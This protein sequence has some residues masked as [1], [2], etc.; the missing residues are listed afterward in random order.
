MKITSETDQSGVVSHEV[1]RDGAD[2]RVK[3]SFA[4]GYAGGAYSITPEHAMELAKALMEAAGPA[5]GRS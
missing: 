3:V 1:E 4:G 2:V 5:S